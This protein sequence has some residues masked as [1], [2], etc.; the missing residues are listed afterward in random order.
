MSTNLMTPKI[1]MAAGRDAANR[2]AK[3]HGRDA[4]NEDDWNVAVETVDRLLGP[5][6]PQSNGEDVLIRWD[7]GNGPTIGH[8]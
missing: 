3:Q 6:D 8:A 4:W 1:A 2:H 7:V 5:L